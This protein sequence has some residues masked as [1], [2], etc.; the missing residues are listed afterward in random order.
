[1][2][3]PWPWRPFWLKSS[4]NRLPRWLFWFWLLLPPL[5]R[6]STNPASYDFDVKGFLVWL[7]NS[8]LVLCFCLDREIRSVFV[9]MFFLFVL[10]IDFIRSELSLV[11]FR[12]KSEGTLGSRRLK[13]RLVF[14]ETSK[15]R[16]WKRSTI[17]SVFGLWKLSAQFQPFALT[18]SHI[19]KTNRV[20]HSSA[21]Y[22]F[23]C[24]F[25]SIIHSTRFTARPIQN[26]YGWP[27]FLRANIS[28]V[29]FSWTNNIF[30][31]V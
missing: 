22:Q 16:E 3:L 5:L 28:M 29:D 17:R 13:N 21:Y 9:C 27:H 31:N 10:L 6:L 4:L 1:M 11:W 30:I 15:W 20:S 24:S 19:I 8:I 2:L 7:S 23:T 26:E 25:A 12:W 18:E 14:H